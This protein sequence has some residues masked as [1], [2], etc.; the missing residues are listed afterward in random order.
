MLENRYSGR[1]L[2]MRGR[3]GVTGDWRNFH[4]EDSWPVKHLTIFYSNADIF[5][6][7]FKLNGDTPFQ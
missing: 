1:Y 6:Q 2:G 5:F 7:V 4:S 3:E